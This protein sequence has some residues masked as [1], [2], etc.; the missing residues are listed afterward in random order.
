MRSPTTPRTRRII[1]LTSDFGLTDVY[2]GVVHG[3]ILGLHP[4]AL[5]VD[6]THAVP[7]QAIE[8]GAFVLL[9]AFESFPPDT[10]HWC[11]VDPGVGTD[12][13]GIIARTPTGWFVGPDNGLVSFVLDRQP[14]LGCWVLDRPGHWRHPVSATFHGRDIFAPTAALLAR[15][16]DADALGTPTAAPP[17]RLAPL[18]SDR[19]ADGSVQ[20]RVVW[21]DRFGNAVTT[22]EASI[23]GGTPHGSV[24]AGA[25]TA[26]VVRT[27][28][29]RPDEPVVALGG[30]SGFL[31]LAAPNGNAAARLGLRVGDAVTLH[32]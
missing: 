22:I 26:P 24:R 4:E 12:R 29:D 11:V 3:V 9:T 18:A 14:L 1:A 10:V 5:I 30:S 32:P 19:R 25:T 2:V 17:M 23:L 6:V 31:E 8:A 28:G 27:Y 7:P 15:G 13:R 20:G 16:E 21:I